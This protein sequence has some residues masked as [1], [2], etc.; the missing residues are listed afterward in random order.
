MDKFLENNNGCNFYHDILNEIDNLNS[1]LNEEGTSDCFVVKN[2]NQ[3]GISK[4]TVCNA[5]KKNNR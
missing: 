3:L 5:I 1:L 2:A 4:G